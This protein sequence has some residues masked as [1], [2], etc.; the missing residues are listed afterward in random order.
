[1]GYYIR[2]LTPASNPVPPALLESAAR[3]RG[4][5]VTGDLGI[6]AWDQIVVVNA[7]DQDVCAID[8]NVVS[9]G[10][11]AQEELAE[12]QS[13]VATCFPTSAAG[14]LKSYLESVRT[15]Y[16]LQILSG[17]EAGNGWEI[18]D[19]VKDAI[20]REAGGI[21]QADGEGFSNEDGYHILWQFSDSVTGHWWM[22]VLKE[23][24]WARFKMD[25]GSQT[26]RAAFLAGEI[27]AGAERAS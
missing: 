6:A 18:L 20:L 10:T 9:G 11:L 19:A 4:G 24:I 26:H 5:K 7:V 14:W 15:I 2:V 3:A 22:A 12:F 21:V 25:L 23:G 8:R 1:M 13:E 27:P 17:T 16:A